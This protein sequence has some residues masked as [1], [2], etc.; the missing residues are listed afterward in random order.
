MQPT[1]RRFLF[2]SSL[3]PLGE[4]LILVPYFHDQKLLAF[5]RRHAVDRRRRLGGEWLHLESITVITGF[6]GYPA[7]FTHLAFLAEPYPEKIS[8]LGTAGSL[9]PKLDNTRLVQVTRIMGSGSLRGFSRR[10]ALDMGAPLI[11]GL[12]PVAG[13]SVDMVQRETPTWLRRQRTRGAEIVEMELFPLRA[14]LKR[15]ITALVV[16]SD[17][18]TETGIQPFGDYDALQREFRRGLLALTQGRLPGITGSGR[19]NDA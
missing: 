6:L 14:R 19:K 3:F 5:F 1:S 10:P 15:D 16:L 12:E 2:Q 13:V 11:K 7:L 4:H 18:V 8:L 17:S 9:A